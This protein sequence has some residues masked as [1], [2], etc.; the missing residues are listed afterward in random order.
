MIGRAFKFETLGKALLLLSFM[1]HKLTQDI[2][3]FF[4]ASFILLI[5]CI[6]KD[7]SLDLSYIIMFKFT[8]PLV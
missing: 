7:R 2:Y 6:L 5:L 1:N 4:T 3:F 8:H